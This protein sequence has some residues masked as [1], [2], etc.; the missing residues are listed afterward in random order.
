MSPSQWEALT[1]Y[2]VRAVVTSA[3][4]TVTKLDNIQRVMKSH[5]RLSRAMNAH[6]I[7][8]GDVA[9]QIGS[10]LAEIRG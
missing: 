1:V 4:D 7:T 6:M 5:E 3:C 10:S 8:T 2:T 9:Q